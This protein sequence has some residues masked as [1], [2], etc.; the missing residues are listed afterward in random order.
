[1]GHSGYLQY[2]AVAVT[3]TKILGKT[4]CDAT[5]FLKRTLEEN[6]SHNNVEMMCCQLLL[7]NFKIIEQVA[8]STRKLAQLY[9]I[10]SIF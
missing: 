7:G 10:F 9:I 3:I 4:D 1:M 6:P 8:F 2:I 5:P